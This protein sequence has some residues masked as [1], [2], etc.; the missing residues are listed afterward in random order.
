MK[1]LHV[2]ERENEGLVLESI[3]LLLLK[4]LLTVI[5]SLKMVV[6]GG[7]WGDSGWRG[8]TVVL[9]SS[10]S[11]KLRLSHF[12]NWNVPGASVAE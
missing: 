5:F 11:E 12:I 4:S 3:V 1:L 10:F 7:A 8:R 6:Q 9:F 2:L